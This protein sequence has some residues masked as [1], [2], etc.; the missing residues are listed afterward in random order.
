MKK[1]IVLAALMIASIVTTASAKKV[2]PEAGL[3]TAKDSL[4]YAM[5]LSTGMVYRTNLQGILGGVENV[6]CKVLSQGFSDGLKG[7]TTKFMM[8]RKTASTVMQYYMLKQAKKQKTAQEEAY[9]KQ[10]PIND[11]YIKDKLSEPG[12]IELPNAASKEDHGTLVKLI[13][14]GLGTPITETDYVCMNYTSKLTNGDVFDESQDSSSVF[15][16]DGVIAGMADALKILREGSEAEIIVPSELGYGKEAVSNGAVPA[17]SI[18]IFDVTILKV[19]HS[20][21]EAQE[22]IDSIETDDEDDE[23]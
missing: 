12:Y 11:Q 16:L 7:D 20:E 5:G 19:F 14:R 3:Q 8:N 15:P 10:K 21:E 1:Q 13:K 17:N 2:E 23:E 6:D 4:S 9:R 22:Y 18:L